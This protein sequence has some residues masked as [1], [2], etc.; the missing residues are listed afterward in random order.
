MILPLESSCRRELHLQASFLFAV[1]RIS[2]NL[3]L[4]DMFEFILVVEVVDFAVT[5][6]KEINEALF[7]KNSEIFLASKTV[8]LNF[9]PA[10]SN[11]VDVVRKAFNV[12][13]G[14]VKI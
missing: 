12:V 14:V 10:M 13:F 11:Q 5:L 8:V 4:E 3:D 2:F 1:D 6:Q 7:R 9:V